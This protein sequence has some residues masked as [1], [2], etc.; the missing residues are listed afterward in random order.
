MG[1]KITFIGC[2]ESSLHLLQKLVDIDANV[3]GV[4][5]KTSSSYNSDFADLTAICRDNQIPYV[6]VSNVND[7]D[8]LRFIGQHPAD[9]AFCFGWSQL[10]KSQVIDSFP[11]GMIGF[12]PA[13]LPNN[14]GRHP[15]IWALVLGMQETA[16]SFFMI[17]EEAD[18]GDIV[19]QRRIPIEYA[20][21]ASSLYGKVIEAACDQEEEIVESLNEG[22][23]LQDV[24]PNTGG[25]SWRKRSHLDGQIDWRMAST[26]IYN[27]VRALTHPY[28]GASFVCGGQEYKVWKVEELPEDNVDNIEP[29]KVL[30]VYSDGSFDVKV[31]G[32]II[33][34][35]DCDPIALREGEYL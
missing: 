10:V 21:D 25:N 15:L 27:L 19:S 29:G 9:I 35:L 18:H 28:V 23:L 20:D 32:G 13:M 1:K 31:Y 26:A 11:E 7:E 8:S 4:I 17:D 6:C 34:V 24:R 16:S 3:V 2:V 5:T 30:R 33:R 22:T 14:K 12:H